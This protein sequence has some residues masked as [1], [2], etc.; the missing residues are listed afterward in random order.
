MGTKI[1][2]LSSAELGFTQDWNQKKNKMLSGAHC[3]FL[4]YYW[5]I[6]LKNMLH[7]R[8]REERESVRDSE[9]F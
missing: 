6:H 2:N 3:T 4:P 7:M 1:L 5:I 9:N 8:A